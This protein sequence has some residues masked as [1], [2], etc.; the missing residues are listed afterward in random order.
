VWLGIAVARHL[1]ERRLRVT[2]VDSAPTMIS[3][4]RSRLPDHEWIVPDMRRLSLRRRFDGILA[5]DP[6]FISITLA[7]SG[8]SRVHRPHTLPLDELI[9]ANAKGM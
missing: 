6:F 2:K 8:C 3:V 9:A 7:S 1:A 4:C 5:S